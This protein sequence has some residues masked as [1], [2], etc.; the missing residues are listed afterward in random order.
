MLSSYQIYLKLDGEDEIRLLILEPGTKSDPIEC[1]LKHAKL[2]EHTEYEAVSY[3]WGTDLPSLPIHINGCRDLVRENLHNAL[4]QLRRSDIARVLWIDALCIN[5]D[6]DQERNRQ[7]AQMGLIYS[8]AA[9]VCVSLGRKGHRGAGLR[10][11]TAQK[12]FDFITKISTT[13]TVTGS[14]LVEAV[15]STQELVWVT[16]F[17]AL[18][19]WKRLWIIQEVALAAKIE[20]YWVESVLSWETLQLF[21]EVV[22]TATMSSEG[23]AAADLN[24]IIDHGLRN[25]V[26]YRLYEQRRRHKPEDMKS[27]ELP[28]HKLVKTYADA[29]CAEKRDKVFALLSLARDCCRKAVPVDYTY[30]TYQLC[31][32]LVK[33]TILSH[34]GYFNADIVF[35]LNQVRRLLGEGS[36]E[37]RPNEGYPHLFQPEQYLDVFFDPQTGERSVGR[38]NILTVRGYLAT[39]IRD[40]TPP[41]ESIQVRREE[42]NPYANDFHNQEKP[43]FFIKDTPLMSCLLETSSEDSQT[44]GKLSEEN[45]RVLKLLAHEA[46]FSVEAINL[47]NH[48]RHRVDSFNYQ[49]F[50][51]MDGHLPESGL[52]GH[53]AQQASLSRII[54]LMLECFQ[55]HPGHAD[56]ILFL[57]DHDTIGLAP[58]TIRPGDRI[59]MFKDE[60]TTFRPQDL[61]EIISDV[62]AA[63]RSVDGKHEIVG[64][65]QLFTFWSDLFTSP[66]RKDYVDFELDIP[67]MLLLS[68]AT[69]NEP[70]SMMKDA[71]RHRN[72]RS[73]FDALKKM[74]E[75]NSSLSEE[76]SEED[77]GGNGELGKTGGDLRGGNEAIGKADSK[78]FIRNSVTETDMDA[79]NRKVSRLSL[80]TFSHKRWFRSKTS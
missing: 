69:Y 66:H 20:I 35:Q 42:K 7:V 52:Q 46:L 16:N 30:S 29:E 62:F 10:P 59:V 79:T 37:E 18:Q 23:Y 58:P 27:M 12:T 57:A 48:H 3:M 9:N 55:T 61:P 65:V 78:G 73:E 70:F 45:E 28:I 40:V 14:G 24:A 33:H 4:I 31:N 44:K 15:R 53:F 68:R 36:A 63:V 22:R 17:F 54:L 34:R 67:G 32:K 5:Q 1:H 43:K 50:P 41:L 26:P 8:T 19:Y 75:A 11:I 80:K 21:L 47:E 77:D 6:D 60:T 25:P 71:W 56:C 74:M 2:S 39:T 72:N 38:D 49:E 51:P 64:R 13:A 76:D